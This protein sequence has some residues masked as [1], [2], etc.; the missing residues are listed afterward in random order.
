MWGKR[1]KRGSRLERQLALGRLEDA[2]GQVQ[3]PQDEEE[4]EPSVAQYPGAVPAPA[5][6]P[7]RAGL[8]PEDVPVD[9]SAGQDPAAAAG[10][11]VPQTPAQQELPVQRKGEDSRRGSFG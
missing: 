6:P 10:D 8:R 7:E 11:S 5:A 2:M 4:G 9:N 1:K 3:Q